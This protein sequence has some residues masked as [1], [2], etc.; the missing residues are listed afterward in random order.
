[1]H[2][3]VPFYILHY[4]GMRRAKSNSDPDSPQV[5]T[6][7]QTHSHTSMYTHMSSHSPPKVHRFCHPY[8]PTQTHTSPSCTHPCILAAIHQCTPTS[9]LT[10]PHSPPKIRRVL[11]TIRHT[12]TFLECCSTRKPPFQ[13]HLPENI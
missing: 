13:G 1:M 7:P 9:N 12:H 4:G 3:S 11:W 5:S 6:L 10:H 8:S 2:Q